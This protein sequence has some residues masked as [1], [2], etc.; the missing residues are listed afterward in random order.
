MKH[1]R[2]YKIAVRAKIKRLNVPRLSV[3]R[4][5]QHIY[6]QV[7][8]PDGTVLAVANSLMPDFKKKL[9]SGANIEAAKLVGALVAKAA[10]KAGVGSVAF[11]RSGKRFHGRIAA[12]A[13]AA[14]EAGL[15]F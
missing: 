2:N 12:L 11:D 6:A 14:R 3:H 5:S 9:K 8:S 4:T 10:Q 1:V 7:T 15:E 13:Q